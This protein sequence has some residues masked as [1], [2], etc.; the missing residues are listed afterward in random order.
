MT[1]P[2]PSPCYGNCTVVSSYPCSQYGS[3]CTMCV[4]AY[5]MPSYN[6]YFDWRLGFRCDTIWQ[7]YYQPQQCSCS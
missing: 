7:D 6:C 5:R 4:F 1:N 2:T 3:T